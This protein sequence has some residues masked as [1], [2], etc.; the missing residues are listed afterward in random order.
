M[1]NIQKLELWIMSCDLLSLIEKRLK[2]N[3]TK[4]SFL[5]DDLSFAWKASSFPKFMNLIFPLLQKF[6]SYTKMVSY[7]TSLFLCLKLNQTNRDKPKNKTRDDAN[8]L[9]PSQPPTLSLS[10]SMHTTTR[11]VWSSNCSFTKTWQKK[12][13]N[14][15]QYTQT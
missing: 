9:Y 4:S 1:E 13:K 6:A 5:P 2:R 10:L 3:S 7:F 14:L 12:R 8:F 11:A 15:S